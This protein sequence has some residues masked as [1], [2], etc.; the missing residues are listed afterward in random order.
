MK[1]KTKTRIIQYQGIPVPAGI[2]TITVPDRPGYELVWA[3]RKPFGFVLMWKRRQQSCSANEIA[4]GRLVGG[5]WVER[6]QACE[7]IELGTEPRGYNVRLCR[8][9][10]RKSPRI[11]A[12]CRWLT[13]YRARIHWN[14]NSQ[15]FR[16]RYER[17][18]AREIC[19][20]MQ[21]KINRG[22]AEAVKKGWITEQ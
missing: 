19:A 2:H 20:D 1:I 6:G 3:G 18:Y 10:G 13:I 14:P 5:W 15:Y 8:L 4:L 11:Q 17:E 9:D 16:A 12:G 21:A 22:E 7:V